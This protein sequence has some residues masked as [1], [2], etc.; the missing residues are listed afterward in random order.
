MGAPTG[1]N[2]SNRP[3][4]AEVLYRLLCSLHPVSGPGCSRVVWSLPLHHHRFCHLESSGQD[5]WCS[6][7]RCLIHHHWHSSWFGMGGSWSPI[8][9]VDSRRQCRLRRH[10]ST[11]SRLVYGSCGMDTLVL[12]QALP[13]GGLRRC[14][15]YVY[16]FS[17]DFGHHHRM[18]KTEKLCRSL[19]LRAGNCAAS[20]LCY[21]PRRWFKTARSHLS[22]ILFSYAGLYFT[23]HPLPNCSLYTKVLTLCL[24]LGSHSHPTSSRYQAQATSSSSIRRPIRCLQR[25]AVQ[26]HHNPIQARRR[27]RVAKSNAGRHSSTTLHGNRECSL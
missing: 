20:Q 15:H 12:F 5:I 27:K 18:G 13:N 19:A 24:R 2:N 1:R 21:L 23:H 4:P 3:S 11:F 6:G 9:Y 14:C 25:H 22:P 7:R 10:S 17:P 26:S 16:S 8:I